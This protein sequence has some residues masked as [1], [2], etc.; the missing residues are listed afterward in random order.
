MRHLQRQSKSFSNHERQSESF[1]NH[2][3]LKQDM[4]SKSP[5]RMTILKAVTQYE[6]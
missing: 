4:K 2:Q 5:N 6:E 3:K 1:S